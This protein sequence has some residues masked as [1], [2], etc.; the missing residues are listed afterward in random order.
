[1]NY[2]CLLLQNL[3]IPIA[4]LASPVFST[5]QQA[6]ISTAYCLYLFF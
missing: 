5:K 6:V 1:L 3:M 4:I 2:T